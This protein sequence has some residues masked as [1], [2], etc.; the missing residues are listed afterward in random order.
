VKTAGKKAMRPRSLRLI[1]ELFRILSE[2]S[3]LQLLNELREGEL[4]VSRL[5]ALTGLNQANVSKQLRILAD[6]KILNRRRQGRLVFYRIVDPAILELCE[7][8]CE[9]MRPRFESE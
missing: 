9:K 8:M 4:S 3:R 5:V 6:G 2:P 7:L 1:A